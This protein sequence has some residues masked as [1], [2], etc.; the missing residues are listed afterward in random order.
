MQ[1]MAYWFRYTIPEPRNQ[2]RWILLEKESST[3]LG[4]CGFHLWDKSKNEVEIGFELLQE[5][6]GKGF[7]LEAV[8]A[9]IGLPQQTM[10]IKKII[11]Q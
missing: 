8:K 7:M 11:T 2:H 1:M 3:K 4:T 5:F 9:I 6:N 10:N